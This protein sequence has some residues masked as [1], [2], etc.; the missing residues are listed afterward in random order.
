MIVNECYRPNDRLPL[1]P[2]G[3]R[4][5]DYTFFGLHLTDTSTDIPPGFHTVRI[6]GHGESLTGVW[7]LDGADARRPKRRVVAA[8]IAHRTPCSDFRVTSVEK[9]Y[10]SERHP[11]CS[12]ATPSPP[13][14]RGHTEPRL[15]QLLDK[16]Y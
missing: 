4:L 2:A 8:L 1:Y 3:T 6:W 15:C 7:S 12:S 16:C 5:C 14:G 11:K 10:R 13:H 9:S